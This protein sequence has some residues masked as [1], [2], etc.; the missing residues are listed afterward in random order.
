MGR[1]TLLVLASLLLASLGTALVWMYVQSA[2][3]R[4][5]DGA[6][7]VTVYVP[8]VPL[9]AN[10]TWEQARD[11]STLTTL[12]T[13][14][15]PAASVTAADAGRLTGQVLGQAVPAGMALTTP[16]FTTPSEQTEAGL[17]PKKFAIEVS[18]SDPQ[19]V[20]GLLHAGSQV[21]ILATTTTSGSGTA[22]GSAAAK[23]DSRTQVLLDAVKVLSPGTSSTTASKVPQSLV[24]L[25]VDLQQAK[26]LA[27]AQSSGEGGA[28][29]WMILR[30]SSQVPADSGQ[31]VDGT[32]LFSK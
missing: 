28:Q 12:S 24:T 10:E 4:A 13:K 7:T 15:V 11:A 29:L 19:R 30:G 31:A 18:L 16:M 14:V 3:R 1:R 6:A 27:F 21:T 23:A 5:L 2:D 9:R 25:E 22:N 26:K 32:N 20:A 17:D 8:N